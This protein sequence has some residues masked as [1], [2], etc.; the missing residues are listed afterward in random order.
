LKSNRF[1]IGEWIPTECVAD[2]AQCITTALQQIFPDVHRRNCIAHIIRHIFDVKFGE[3][4]IDKK[5]D[6]EI[7]KNEILEL[8]NHAFENHFD[9]AAAALIEKW[10]ES[11]H[12]GIVEFV[13]Q[14][15]EL[16]EIILQHYQELYF[17]D[18]NNLI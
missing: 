11:D 15:M 9:L 3:F 6:G 17:I 18:F 12:V 7:M 16:Q 8:A 14:S 13:K 4:E 1:C 5:T 10:K 2:N